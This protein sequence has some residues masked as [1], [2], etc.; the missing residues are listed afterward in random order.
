VS[1][2]SIILL[3]PP[4]RSSRYRGTQGLYRVCDKF[5]GKL[6]MITPLWQRWVR[7]DF[8]I[9]SK[10][11]LEIPFC[12]PFPKGDFSLPTN[13]SHTQ[14]NVVSLSKIGI[15]FNRDI[16]T[17]NQIVNKTEKRM[18]KKKSYKGRILQYYNNT[19]TQACPYFLFFIYALLGIHFGGNWKWP[20]KIPGTV[21]SSSSSSQ[22]KA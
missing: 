16:A 18:K 4:I 11:L 1:G 22:R 2:V 19:I 21:M 12:S 7:G 8:L 15:R 3:K 5:V 17:M 6:W 20:A 9:T 10:C 14:L 13:L